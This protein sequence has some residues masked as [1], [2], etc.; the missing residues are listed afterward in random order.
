VREPRVVRS[1]RTAGRTALA[2]RPDAPG[3]LSGNRFLGSAGLVLGEAECA[4][5]HGPEPGVALAQERE[6]LQRVAGRA[7]EGPPAVLEEVVDEVDR[8]A[9][10]D[11]LAGREGAALEA[12]A[13]DYDP[14]ALEP[15]ADDGR[16]GR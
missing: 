9:V 8:A 13:A 1:N 5:Q 3:L 6:Q 4:G 14:L 11:E 7:L 16:R 2:V 10:E 12:P 15:P